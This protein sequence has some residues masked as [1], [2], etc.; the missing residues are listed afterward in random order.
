MSALGKDHAFLTEHIRNLRGGS[1][2][3]LAQASDGLLYVVKFINNL[4][5][6]NL[7][8]NEG[9]GAELYRACG[10]AV[11]KWKPLLVTDSFLDRNP[12]CWMQAPEGRLRPL[13][14][15][16]FAS[17]YLGTD[18][19]R[20]QEFLPAT[21]FHLISNR[22][23]FWLAWLLDV[24][25]E[26]VDNRQAVFVERADARLDAFYIDHGHLFG[27]PNAALRKHFCASRYLDPRIYPDISSKNLLEFQRVVQ[28]LNVDRLWERVQDF[29][30]DWKQGSALELFAR[31]LQRLS[32]PLLL[33]N[34][35][36]TV[37]ESIR[38]IHGE[39][40]T[41]RPP[42]PGSE[43]KLPVSVLRPG[44]QCATQE[45]CRGPFRAHHPA[46]A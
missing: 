32:K 4:Q 37:F 14:G 45:S 33:H 5:G 30:T 15:M 41:I 11:P 3:I 46:C 44:L 2:P 10:L 26:H 38:E 16:C 31:C 27:G 36:D 29:P 12:D 1:Q 18:G 19:V 21:S 22:N 9:A 8:F 6:P 43:R 35:L 34:V 42:D 40:P 13:P 24:C 17:S 23:S 20:L 28:A 39:A 25:A 7:L